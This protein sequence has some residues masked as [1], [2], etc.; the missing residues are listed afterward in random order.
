MPGTKKAVGK[1]AAAEERVID[2]DVARVARAEKRGGSDVPRL[3]LGGELKELPVEIPLE[4]V[5]AFDEGRSRAGLLSLLGT[6]AEEL[7]GELSIED[8][9]ALVEGL[10]KVYGL[11]EGK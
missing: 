6:D 3:K 5:V 10:Y 7:I 9:E 4:A 11:D 8:T 2:L 1:A